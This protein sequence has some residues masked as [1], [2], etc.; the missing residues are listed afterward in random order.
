MIL[1]NNGFDDEHEDSPKEKK[2]S[3]SKTIGNRA[4]PLSNFKSIL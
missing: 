2:V 3:E 4:S 1:N